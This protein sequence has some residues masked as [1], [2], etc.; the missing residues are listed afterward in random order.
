MRWTCWPRPGWRTASSSPPWPCAAGFAGVGQAYLQAQLAA[1]VELRVATRRLI[2]A[3]AKA[4]YG[5]EALPNLIDAKVG[6]GSNETAT[7][8]LRVLLGDGF[9]DLAR[10]M[11]PKP[12]SL[13]KYLIDAVCGPDD[14]VLDFFAGSGV[15]GQAVMELN[16]ENGLTRRFIL[17]QSAEP[18]GHTDCPTIAEIARRRLA[19]AA[20][21][22]GPGAATG[23]AAHKLVMMVPAVAALGLRTNSPSRR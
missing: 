10:R 11:R 23:I 13:L 21:R 5:R 8:E 15:T 12:V 3:Y 22:P 6:V 17:V 4:R 19:A 20:G 16:A 9:A 14:L 2:P 18:T 1:G 7:A